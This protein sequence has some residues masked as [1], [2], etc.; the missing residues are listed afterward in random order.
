LT[1]FASSVLSEPRPAAGRRIRV[2][3]VDDSAVARRLVRQAL[4]TSSRIEVVGSAANGRIA[5]R[6]VADRQ[7]DAVTL[8]IEM[9][10][11]NG[12]ET[13]REIRRAHPKVRIVM[14][15]TLAVPGATATLDALA[16]GADDYVLKPS[17][18]GL[19]GAA[20]EDFAG[21]LAAKISQF[22]LPPLAEGSGAPPKAVPRP[23]SRPDRA[24]CVKPLA[25]AIA[26][27]TGGPAA[28]AELLPNLPA[29]FPAPVFIT[30]H[31]PPMFTRLLGER[32][33]SISPLRVQEA[34][35]GMTVK[36]GEVYIAPGNYHMLVQ[37]RAGTARI[38]LDQGPPENSCRPA[39]D[40]MFRSIGQVYG[41]AVVA[42]ILTGMGQD[43]M[44]G[45]AAL[46]Q[47]G[48]RILA[49]DEPTSVVWGMP[50]AVA[51]AGL[52]D[53]ILRLQDIPAELARQFS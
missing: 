26:V 27:S 21:Q 38:R 47:L 17:S 48:A 49:Q 51:G 4:E 18:A 16:A 37:G 23:A 29:G 40:P 36:P 6:M 45:A 42:V 53:K 31:M 28:L 35:D 19:N 13:A 30:Q 20:P 24:P 52:A 44:R 46:R 43:G 50:G 22:F 25:L 2:L 8:D 3:V 9:P 14:L 41:G 10:D 32:L 39:A 1:S 15:S 5:L 11:L 34:A 33:D 12:L 7:P